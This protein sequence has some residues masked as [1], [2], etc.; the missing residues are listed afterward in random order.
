MLNIYDEYL[1]SSG[2]CTDTRKIEANCLFFALKG[3]NFDGNQFVDEALNKGAKMAV[4][5]DPSK[6]VAGKTILVHDTLLALQDLAKIH[7]TRLSIPII[8]LTGSNGK[9]TTKELIASVLG[10]THNVFATEG[11]LNNHI[12]VPL[13][14]LSINKDHEIAIIEMGANH[15]KEIQFL[16]EIAQPDYGL[17]TNIGRAHLEGFGGIE[18]VT[19]GKKELYDY[20]ESSDGTLFVNAADPKL[21]EIKPNVKTLYYGGNAPITG[22]SIDADDFLRFELTVKQEK[23][24][25]ETQLVGD[26][27]LSNALAAAC[28]GAQFNLGIKDIQKGLENY[29]PSNHRSQ[30]IKTSNNRVVLDAYNSNPSSVEVAIKNFSKREDEQKLVVLGDMLELGDESHSEHSK[31]IHLL[32]E[33]HLDSILVGSQFG[34][35]EQ[36]SF[37][38]FEDAKQTL[39]YLQGNPIKGKII[40]IKGS[41]GIQLETILPAL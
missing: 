39:S 31:I 11:N 21:V 40:L 5:D 2:V 12:G 10:T 1:S 32:E 17:I 14:I 20:I 3:D 13:S 36:Q 19:K 4:I 28:I 30:L 38:H 15:Q 26:Y 23:I 25:V 6:Q 29:V 8:G 24:V 27:N 18:G 16:S 37:I 22:S 41:R 35:V 34:L 7:R 9:T 33:L